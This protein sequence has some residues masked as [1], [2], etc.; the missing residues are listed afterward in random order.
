MTLRVQ[1][2]I[3]M[4]LYLQT[5][6]NALCSV[7]VTRSVPTWWGHSSAAVEVDTITMRNRGDVKVKYIEL[8]WI[9][10]ILRNN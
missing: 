6:M 2:T 5:G 1:F 9:R 4:I 3:V 10:I 8:S 7:P